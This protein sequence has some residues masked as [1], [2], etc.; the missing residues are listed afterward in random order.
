MSFS[1]EKW[2]SYRD[3][4]VECKIGIESTVR[5]SVL[6]YMNW[7]RIEKKEIIDVLVDIQVP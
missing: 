4:W 6:I 2:N 1:S 3:V 7:S 5:F